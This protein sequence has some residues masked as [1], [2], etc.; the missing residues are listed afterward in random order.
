[1]QLTKTDKEIIIG[2]NFTVQLQDSSD[3]CGKHLGS[4]K[5]E[6]SLDAKKNRNILAN[7]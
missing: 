7:K 2:K 1:M 3:G 6:A 5:Q 4:W